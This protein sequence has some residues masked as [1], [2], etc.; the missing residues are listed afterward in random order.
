M[1]VTVAMMQHQ[2]LAS[3]I[4]ARDLDRCGYDTLIAIT[5][6][7]DYRCACASVARVSDCT[8]SRDEENMKIKTLGAF[9]AVALLAACSTPKSPDASP[10]ATQAGIV[11]GSQRIVRVLR[12]VYNDPSTSSSESSKVSD[13]DKQS[14]EI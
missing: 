13:N 5:D 7:T 10:T 12:R 9:A 1:I 4:G 2:C 14:S 8:P 6:G 11:P 3:C